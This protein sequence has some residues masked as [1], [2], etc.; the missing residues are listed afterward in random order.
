MVVQ[1]HGEENGSGELMSFR[2]GIRRVI[3]GVPRMVTRREDV[4]MYGMG[5]P[6]TDRVCVS[7]IRT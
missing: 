1:T 6:G 2:G 5:W 4:V 3:R 7:N